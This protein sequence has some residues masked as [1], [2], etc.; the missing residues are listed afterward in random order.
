LNIRE[1][2]VRASH[3]DNLVTFGSL[4]AAAARFFNAAARSGLNVLVSGGDT[5]RQDKTT[6]LN[7][8]ASAVPP[9][10]RMMTCEEI[11][12]LTNPWS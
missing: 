6:L 1:F 11:S 8:V 2:V 5:G 10:E 4:T 12:E 7:R 9:Q 3:L